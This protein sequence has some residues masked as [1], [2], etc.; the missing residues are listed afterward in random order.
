MTIIQFFGG[1]G[2]GKSSVAYK[3]AG[4]LKSKHINC[5]LVTE[6]AKDV[7][8]EKNFHQLKNQA[9]KVILFGLQFFP[10]TGDGNI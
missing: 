5:E 4:A 1:P 3:L 9:A 6:V 10:K 2:S 8:W 7:T